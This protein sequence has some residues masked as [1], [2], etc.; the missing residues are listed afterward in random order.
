MKMAVKSRGTHDGIGWVGLCLSVALPA[1]AATGQTSSSFTSTKQAIDPS[2]TEFVE[3]QA[4]RAE[5]WGLD[6][7]E[8]QRYQTLLQGIRGSVSPAT[9][10]PIEVLGIHARSAEE[11]RRYA[12]Q[13][14]VLMRDDAERIL[15]FQHAYD[16][17]Q[18]RLFP[19]GLLI[20]TRALASSTAQQGQTATWAWQPEDRVLF[21]TQTQCPTC[22]A[23]LERL[24]SQIQQFAGIDLYLVDL[25]AGEE[26]RLRDW[27]A[28]QQIDPQW[29]RAH[30]LTLNIDAGALDKVSSH[31]GQQGQALPLLILRRNHQLTPLSVSHF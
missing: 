12:E 15:A 4:L 14:A 17:A 2:A 28:A 5:Q 13:W 8:W 25:D 18:R 10:S 16:D 24:V 22:D 21:F 27:A 30:K 11:R 20:D 3:H 7:I 9:L 19:M 29:V 1:M 6:E 31:T 26:S 23:V